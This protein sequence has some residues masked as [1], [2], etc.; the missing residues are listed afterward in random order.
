LFSGVL[1]DSIEY[2]GETG[3]EATGLN[4]L[5]MAHSAKKYAEIGR[6]FL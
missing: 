3:I 4:G 6:D 2:N 5:K 1:F